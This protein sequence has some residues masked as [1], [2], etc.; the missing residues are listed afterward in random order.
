MARV[1]RP[2]GIVAVA[3]E[4]LLLEEY[5]H[6]EY[7]TPSEIAAELVAPFPNLSLVDPL[8][9]RTLPYDYLVD[10]IVVPSGV[11]R[12]RRHV[13]LN[14]GSVQWTSVMLVYRVRA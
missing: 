6:P 1:V 4:M 13:V 8:E 10:S 9:L 11:D 5:R 2:G 12:R 14:D 3:T 7:F